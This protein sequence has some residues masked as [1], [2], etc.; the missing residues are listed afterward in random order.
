MAAQLSGFRS[1]EDPAT[2]LRRLA[3]ATRAFLAAQL[4]GRGLSD[5]T[6]GQVVAALEGTA[7]DP[8]LYAAG[9]VE[10][11]RAGQRGQVEAAGETAAAA[12]TA[13]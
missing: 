7:V 1:A 6:L 10:E 2:V 11:V 13:G 5:A 8:R 9:A 3:A 12:N 4:E